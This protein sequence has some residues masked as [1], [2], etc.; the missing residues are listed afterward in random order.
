MTPATDR[1]PLPLHARG[2]L[3]LRWLTSGAWLGLLVCLL[4]LSGCGGGGS[5]EA[6]PMEGSRDVQTIASRVNGSSYPLNVYLPPASAG[7]RS[8]LPVIYALDGEWWFEVL[9]NIAETTHARV[10]I[11][12]IGNPALRGR[13]YVP[14]N[15][16]TVGGGGHVA[17]LNFIG[18]ELIPYIERTFG[19]DPARRV[20]LGH[21]HGGSFVLYAMFAQAPGQHLFS[22]YLASDA[23]VSCMTDTAYGWERSY[24]ASYSE[25]P[26]RLHLS[27]A[28]GGNYEAN[29]RYSQAIEQRRYARLAFRAQAYD[30]GHTGIIP[31]A[32]ADAVAFALA[33]GP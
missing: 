33:T 25:L 6:V 11:V 10:I 13:D 12:G 14:G 24:A 20:L 5:G 8:A 1:L 28:T 19:G 27:Y 23:S 4:V 3:P 7:P 21:S 26:V 31:R 2:R 17:Y 30:G 29:L 22:A 9:V 15:F 32:F 16:C 18:S